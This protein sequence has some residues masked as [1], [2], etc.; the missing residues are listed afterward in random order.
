MLSATSKKYTLTM[1]I[2]VLNSRSLRPKQRVSVLSNID[3]RFFKEGLP[4]L[5]SILSFLISL[6]IPTLLS[7]I[8][9]NFAFNEPICSF[10]PLISSLWSDFQLDISSMLSIPPSL[11]YCSLGQVSFNSNRVCLF[12]I[13]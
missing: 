10:N 5:S 12:S 2:S 9:F 3:T 8:F 11:L 6:T 13:S 7:I 1:I 4:S